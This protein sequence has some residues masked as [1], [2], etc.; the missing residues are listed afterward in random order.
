MY[1]F[2]AKTL[3]LQYGGLGLLL[4]M[5]THV[6]LRPETQFDFWKKPAIL[7]MLAFLLWQIWKSWDSIAPVLSWQESSRVFWLPVF[8]IALVYFIQ[9]PEQ[10]LAL[11]KFIVMAAIVANIYACCC[12]IP[13]LKS[14]IFGSSVK[15]GRFLLD[16][17]DVPLLGDALKTFFYPQEFLD[18]FQRKLTLKQSKGEP[19]FPLTSYSFFPG[20]DDAGTFGNKNFLAAYINLSTPFIFLQVLSLY[21]S[22]IKNPLLSTF[23]RLWRLALSL[24]LLTVA[25]GSLWLL[26]ALQT[27]GAWLGFAAGIG[28]T[29]LYVVRFIVP[30]M[31]R[32]KALLSLVLILALGAAML[33]QLNPSRFKSIFSASH[34]GTNELRS[35]T[36]SKYT[37]AWWSDRE[38]SGFEGDAHRILTG[39][40]QYTFRVVYPKVRSPRIFNIEFNQ[41]NT[42]TSHAHNEYLSYLGELGLV[43]LGLYLLLLWTLWRALWQ[44][45]KALKLEDL[46][47]GAAI[48]FALI[49][50]LTHQA[51]E[52]SVRYTGVAFQLWLCMGLLLTLSPFRAQSTSTSAPNPSFLPKIWPKT[53][54]FMLLGL[55]LCAMPNWLWPLKWFR[56]QHQFEMGQIYFGSVREAQQQTSDLQQNKVRLVQSMQNYQQKNL[57]LPEG[58]KKELQACQEKETRLS[59]MLNFYGPLAHQYFIAAQKTDPANFESLYIGAI[60][61][62]QLANGALMQKNSPVAEKHYELALKSLTI[63]EKTMPYFVQLHYWKGLCWKGLAVLAINP[64]QSEEKFKRALASLDRYAGQ[65]PYF[66]D[67]FLDRYFCYARLQQKD[68]ALD[69]LLQFLLSLEKSGEPLF[70]EQR[71]YDSRSI[72]DAI[73]KDIDP[74]HLA[75]AQAAMVGLMDHAAS[76]CL[77][78]FVPKTDRH[79]KNS[80]RL[81]REQIK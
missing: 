8:A 20:K 57:P 19:I 66:K 28:V 10:R 7:A 49:T 47:L 39:F 53:I 31:H 2:Q 44:G 75:L 71:R 23:S 35:L 25:L 12:F 24:L 54:P 77:L 9:R 51:L 80:F 63:I 48:V 73:L 67:M 30:Q 13:S 3:L 29:G 65:D 41:H 18:T 32:F 72:L 43:G 5:L 34:G 37:Q 78:P 38:W 70:D 33:Y 4:L 55:S 46:W 50:Q 76:T 17:Y 40:G 36:W 69:Q 74:E 62:V 59:R 1:I 79:I 14:V 27:R 16:L 6:F 22:V 26:V 81:L 52:V 15:E 11:V 58:L 68:R 56:S 42:E 60:M 61:N 21:W 45:A 64:Q